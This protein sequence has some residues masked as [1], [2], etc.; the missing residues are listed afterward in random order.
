MALTFTPGGETDDTLVS[1]VT[2]KTH[3]ANFGRNYAEFDDPY[4]EIAL[5][6]ATLWVEGL[7]SRTDTRRTLWPGTRTSSTQS[8]IWPRSGA[9]YID[10]SPISSDA[11]PEGVTIAVCEAAY[12][13][14][15]DSEGLFENVIQSQTAKRKK[16]GPM[17]IEYFGSDS[18]DAVRKTL[19]IVEDALSQILIPEIKG[20]HLSFNVIGNGDTSWD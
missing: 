3:C 2:F 19:G 18:M 6:K 20:R 17:E 7:G 11:I 12:F 8:R 5:R 15:T 16:I 4:L 13:I 10:N 9:K 14:L 1:L